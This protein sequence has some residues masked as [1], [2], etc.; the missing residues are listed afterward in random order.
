MPPNLVLC[1]TRVQPHSSILKQ[2][3]SNTRVSDLTAIH[4]KSLL[5]W[6]P[7][8]LE[9]GPIHF[10][11]SDVFFGKTFSKK[12]SNSFSFLI[13]PNVTSDLIFT[14]YSFSGLK[15]NY[16]HDFSFDLIRI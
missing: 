16:I 1:S 6:K 7:I 11:L 13:H 3:V 9:A 5:L 4:S 10:Q 14:D 2:G 8:I 15:R 12:S